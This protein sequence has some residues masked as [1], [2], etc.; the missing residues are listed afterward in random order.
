MNRMMGT[1]KGFNYSS[2]APAYAGVSSPLPRL[3]TVEEAV[4]AAGLN[5]EVALA[6]L[7]TESGLVVPMAK[8]VVRTDTDTVLGTVGNRYTILQNRAAADVLADVVGRDKAVFEAGGVL[9]DGALA[10]LILKLRKDIVLPG[11]DVIE[12]RFLF[13]TAH[14]GSAMTRVMSLPFR[15]FCA[16]QLNAAIAAGKRTGGSSLALRHTASIEERLKEAERV[17]AFEEAFYDTFEE[18]ARRM[19]AVRFGAKQMLSF[20]E[21]LFPSTRM[22]GEAPAPQTLAAREKVIELY[23]VGE[24]QK[25]NPTARGTVWAAFNAV[26]EYADHYRRTRTADADRRAELRAESNWFGSGAALKQKAMD[27]LLPKVK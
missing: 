2:R 11:D 7:R 9:K 25:D 27:L 23:E 24:G 26:T 5:Y 6:P 20:A 15:L 22:E 8:A 1:Q 17:L 18:L 14:D 16:N 19:L 12:R 10:F 3:A 4:E 13:Y 21:E